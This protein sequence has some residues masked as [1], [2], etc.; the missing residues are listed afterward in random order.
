MIGSKISHYRIEAE[1]GRGGMGVV[2]RARD[3]RLRRD[4]ALKILPEERA[5][6][7][8]RRARILA[9]A[10]AAAA[11][12]HPAVTTIYE[13]GEEGDQLFIVMEL[14]AGQ[15]LRAVLQQGPM[16]P[17][18]LIRMAAQ[19]AEGL[20]LAHANGVVHGDIKPENIILLADGRVKLLDFGIARQFA[21]E[22]A[23]LTR[24]LEQTPSGQIAGTVAYMAPEQLRGN[25][26]DAR[27]DLFS[28]GVVLYELVAGRRPFLGPTGM[29]LISQILDDNP[30]PVTQAATATPSELGRI[31]HKLLEK[32]PDSRYQSAHELR[33]DLANLSR[34][35]EAGTSRLAAVAGKR[36]VA[37]LPFKLL[38]PNPE[39]DYLSG[40]LADAVSNQLSATGGVLVRPTSTVLRYAKPGGDPLEAARDLNV[41]VL[42]DGSIQ[43]LGQR[44]R[45]HAQAW[46]AADGSSLLSAKYDSD[47]ADLFGLQDK[48]ADAVAR[49]LGTETAAEKPPPAP[50]STNTKAYEIYMRAGERLARLN[51]W[52]MRTA[53]EMLEDAVRLDPRFADAWARLAEA[54][55][56]MGVTFEPQPRWFRRAEQAIRRAL[57]L[58]PENAEAQCARGQVLWT[59]AKGFQ[60]RAALRA[61]ALALRLNPGCQQ[62]RIQR[63]LVLLHVGLMEGARQALAEALATNPDDSRTLV[64]IGQ[65]ALYQGNLEEADEYYTRALRLDPSG[66]W[67]NLFFPNVALYRGQLERAA[68]SIAAA[69]KV[70]PGEPTS[71]SLE[72][73]LWAHRGEKRRAEQTL[74]RALRGGKPV[75]HTHHMLHNVAAA[76]ATLGKPAPVI[77]L[78]RK[79]SKTGLPNYPAFRDDPHF[80]PLRNHPPFLRLMSDLRRTWEGYQREFGATSIPTPA[81]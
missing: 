58:D 47:M 36:A 66:L 22:T 78:L 20:A 16:Q 67:A 3:E 24:A 80:A 62:A 79:A 23:T 61:Q 64:F 15:T 31:I 69:Q 59:P 42:I 68:E 50:P 55:I 48:L 74:R 17:L 37:V 38:T 35:L 72:G 41:Q 49:A 73:L 29:A 12:N 28:L 63:G 71:L 56:Q 26:T 9:E 60:N 19:V 2:Y 57:A 30:A 14:L 18:A 45:V 25:A 51:R 4:V 32:Q 27:A 6:H 53:I 76:Y 13:V 54:C 40:A 44:L 33:V 34:D 77:A 52:D 75:L 7:A 21:E 65:A 8:D 70:L 11:L 5:G 81:R 43:K 39:D 1:L 10:R 46:N